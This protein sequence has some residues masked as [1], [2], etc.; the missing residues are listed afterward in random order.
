MYSLKWRWPRHNDCRLPVTGQSVT[1]LTL[2]S[3]PN[4]L[5]ITASAFTPKRAFA[6]MRLHVACL[7]PGHIFKDGSWRMAVNST[8]ICDFESRNGDDQFAGVARTVPARV[9]ISTSKLAFR[10]SCDKAFNF[11]S[12]NSPQSPV[13][14]STRPHFTRMSWRCPFLFRTLRNGTRCAFR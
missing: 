11:K 8:R 3:L 9:K 4:R 12:P 2:I 14:L 1:R 5:Q 13:S 10:G 7:V 6:I